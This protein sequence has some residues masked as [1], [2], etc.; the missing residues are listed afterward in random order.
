[1]PFLNEMTLAQLREERDLVASRMLPDYVQSHAIPGSVDYSP[2][3][4]WKNDRD[5]DRYRRI[6]AEIESRAEL[7]T[8]V[9]R[10]VEL[11]SDLTLDYGD[12][13]RAQERVPAG[14]GGSVKYVT[15]DGTLGVR[16]DTGTVI[17]VM[18]GDV[19]TK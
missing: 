9:G 12:T 11:R 5:R 14:T 17:E 16:W 3:Y 1:M 4:N 6:V 13:G 2:E 15:D 7:A 8:Q 10:R 18:P 19:H